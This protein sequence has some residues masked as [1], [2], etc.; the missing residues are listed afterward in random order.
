MR[1]ECI[2]SKKQHQVYNLRETENIFSNH[3]ISL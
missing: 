1:G 3:I 2:N